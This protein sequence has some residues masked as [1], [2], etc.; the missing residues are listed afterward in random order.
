MT[1]TPPHP[2]RHADAQEG[3]QVVDDRRDL[4]WIN[5]LRRALQDEPCPTSIDAALSVMEAAGI[6]E[7]NYTELRADVREWRSAWRDG[8]PWGNATL[9]G[10]AGYVAMDAS[11]A[12]VPLLPA[13]GLVAPGYAPTDAEAEERALSVACYSADGPGAIY[14]ALNAEFSSSA[15]ATADGELSPR[16][17]AWLPFAKLL[18]VALTSLPPSFIFGRDSATVDPAI[19]GRVWRAVKHVF[20]GYPGFVNS[21]AGPRP[22]SSTIPSGTFRPAPP[23]AGACACRASVGCA[24]RRAND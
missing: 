12:A 2:P 7:V 6:T 13:L 4:A 20:P 3:P 9:L 24:R 19:R 11:G 18:E 1:S 14:G 21:R 15:R 10:P 23:S 5:T 16:V 22:P 17:R 8:R